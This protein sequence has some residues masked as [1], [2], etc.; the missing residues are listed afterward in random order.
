MRAEAA[1]E[2]RA[3]GGLRLP[4]RP[5]PTYDKTAREA[6]AKGGPR[7]PERPEPT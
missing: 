5:E 1:R 6:R 2:S 7:L 4:E 3:K